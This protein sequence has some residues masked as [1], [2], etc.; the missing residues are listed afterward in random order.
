[1]DESI[2]VD[3]LGNLKGSDQSLCQS[4][5]AIPKPQPLA[6]SPNGTIHDINGEKKNAQVF[7]GEKASYFRL[8]IQGKSLHQNYAKTW[9]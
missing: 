1:M 7:A 5:L 4:N 8:L 2:L 9:D 6:S 3:N